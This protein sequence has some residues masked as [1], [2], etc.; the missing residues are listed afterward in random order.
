MEAGVV[1]TRASSPRYKVTTVLLG[2]KGVALVD[3]YHLLMSLLYERR[4]K[5]RTWDPEGLVPRASRVIEGLKGDLK[6]YRVRGASDHLFSVTEILNRKRIKYVDD[7]HKVSTYLRAYAGYIQPMAPVQEW[8]VPQFS[9]IELKLAKGVGRPKKQRRRAW[10]ERA[11]SYTGVRR[12]CTLCGQH[13][14]NI[15]CKGPPAHV[16]KPRVRKPRKK[17][18]TGSTTADVSTAAPTGIQRHPIPMSQDAVTAQTAANYFRVHGQMPIQSEGTSQLA[19]R[20]F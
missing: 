19:G 18:A 14:H 10:D 11:K 13:G 12:K 6:F 5:A 20:H 7:Y 1:Q 8:S 16:R 2:F 9:V 17:N 15:T 4:V 3:K